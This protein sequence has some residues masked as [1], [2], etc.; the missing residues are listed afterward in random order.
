V[1]TNEIGGH[2]PHAPIAGNQG[3][4]ARR[5]RSATGLKASAQSTSQSCTLTGAS[6]SANCPRSIWARSNRSS[7]SSS[8]DSADPSSNANQRDSCRSHREPTPR[9]VCVALHGEAEDASQIDPLKPRGCDASDLLPRHDLAPMD[10]PIRH[11]LRLCVV[12]RHHDC[13]SGARRSTRRQ[14]RS[15]T[16]A[17]PSEGGAE[18][19]RTRPGACAGACRSG[20]GLL[21]PP[22]HRTGSL[23]LFVRGLNFRQVCR[24]AAR[25]PGLEQ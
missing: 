14:G 6:L 17:L 19:V 20:S 11:G 1:S 13:T 5:S 4:T 7:I 18:P 24:S 9:R 2:H 12:P 21:A 25:K 10:P 16:P 15:P 3:G 8:N 22:R 23:P